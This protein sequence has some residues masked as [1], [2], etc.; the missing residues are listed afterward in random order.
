[1]ILDRHVPFST[2]FNFRDLGGYPGAAGRVVRTG[3][4]YRADGLFRLAESDL[5]RFHALGLRTVLDLRRAD[6]LAADG[7][8]AESLDLDYVNIDFNRAPWPPAD[9]DPDEMPR[10]Y[11]DRYAEM[12]D[13]GLR[14]D[15][16]VGQ[17]L[18]M[19]VER[20]RMPMVFHCAAGKDRTGVLAALVLSL[21][22]VD[23]DTI[24]ADYALSAEGERR[25]YEWVRGGAAPRTNSASTEG[26]VGVATD[27]PWVLN[28]CPADAML[29][30]LG[31]L[32]ERHGSVEDYA[33]KAGFG[34]ADVTELRR[35]LLS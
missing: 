28:P 34:A 26:A 25:Y 14:H 30:F 23:D 10:Y 27:A 22:G 6:E 8:I 32:R 13:D 9:L 11:A 3:V 33:A 31:E 35:H 21:V 20:E 19:F 2:V 29:M 17:A 12:V 5:E 18:R 24:A 16:P 7:R 15:N 4:L 1:V